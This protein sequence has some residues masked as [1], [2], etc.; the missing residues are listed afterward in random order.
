M[1]LRTKTFG[2]NPVFLSP[3]TLHHKKNF[4][5]YKVLASTC[6]SSCK[7]LTAPKGFITDG[8]EKLFRAWK[9]ELPKATHLRCIHYF[10]SNCKEK[11]RETGIREAKSQKVF[12]N[13]VFGIP[14]KMDGVVDAENKTEVKE[15]LQNKKEVLDEK[16]KESSYRPL[17][18]K[19]LDERRRMIAKT[20]RLKARRK[21]GM[22][23][24]SNGKPARPYTNG[25]EAVNKVLLQTK[26]SYF[27]EKKKPETTQL[28]KL[29]FTKNIFEEVHWK[30]LEKP[31]M[32]VI[33]LSDQYELSKIAAH[34]AVPAEV[35][36]EWSVAQRKEYIASSTRCQSTT[37]FPKKPSR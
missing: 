9:T 10:Q 18:S 8:E 23:T 20:I 34:L 5:T 36:F 37:L 4:D 13:K 21:A 7:G 22:P 15:Q 12:L 33:G 24:G 3:T 28:S 35:W 2:Q 30:Q 11:L 26:E 6:V 14:E 17:F 27:R 25:S 29:E 1:F 31:T 32:A 19:F 16:E